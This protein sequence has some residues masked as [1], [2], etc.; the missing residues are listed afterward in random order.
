MVSVQQFIAQCSARTLDEHKVNETYKNNSFKIFWW[1]HLQEA[2][3]SCGEVGQGKT[4]LERAVEFC[5]K[6]TR[7]CTTFSVHTFCTCSFVCL[8]PPAPT[9]SLMTLMRA[10][11][12]LRMITQLTTRINR[13]KTFRR[14]PQTSLSIP[15]N[16]GTYA[17]FNCSTLT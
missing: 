6:S 15:S 14:V 13:V 1:F 16:V 7:Y 10:F 5:T 3:I 17:R 9:N 11:A 8:T 4:A 2:L 12:R